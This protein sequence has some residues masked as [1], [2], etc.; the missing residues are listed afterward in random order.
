MANL[1]YLVH[2]M[3]YPPNKGD[4]V[5]SYH[6]LKH[7]SRA[8]PRFLGTFVDDPTTAARR[9]AARAV[10]RAALVPLNPRRAQAAQPGGVA[11]RRG[12]DTALLPRRRPAALG[13]DTAARSA[14]T[15][16]SCSRRRW[17]STSIAAAAPMLVDLVDVDSDKW[18]QYASAHRWPSRGYRREGRSCSRSSGGGGPVGARHLGHGRGGRAVPRLAP[19]AGARCRPRQWRRRRFFAPDPRARRPSTRASCPWSSPARWIT[20]LTSMPCAG[21]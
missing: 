15:P 8:V 12:P 16:R 20:G 5:R 6:L 18:T 7:L 9:Q 11:G 10:R 4:K 13:A 14:S 3:P 2:R 1:L 19:E 21:S 17:H